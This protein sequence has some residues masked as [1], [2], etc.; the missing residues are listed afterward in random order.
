MNARPLRIVTVVVAL[1]LCSGAA[2]L[3]ALGSGRGA[4][5]AGAAIPASLA[6]ALQAPS[7]TTTGAPP[8]TTTTTTRP[9]RPSLEGPLPVPTRPPSDPY[10]NVA[11]VPIGRIE[12]P[13]IGLVHTVYEGI[14]LTVI[15][16]G[17]GHWPGSALP[18]MLGNTVFPGHRVT[19]SHPFLDLDRLVPG[20]E[21]RF[22]MPYGTFTYRVTETLVVTPKDLWVVDQTRD[23]TMTLIACHPK[24][25]A[26]Q[27]IVVKGRL[28]TPSP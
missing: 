4:D 14:W 2:A 8:A 1:S 13:A 25:S 19:H 5:L 22:V 23:H 21:V 10:E 3:T 26:R 16:E 7:T 12:I 27:R 11:V 24:H 15:D 9:A 17:P 28:V 18:G 20:D 6:A